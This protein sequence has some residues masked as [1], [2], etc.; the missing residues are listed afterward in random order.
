MMTTDGIIFECEC[1][2]TKTHRVTFDGGESTD[3][4][5]IEM[6]QTCYDGD[7]KMYMI[8]DEE[9]LTTNHQRKS[10][11]SQTIFSLPEQRLEDSI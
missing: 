9:I 10:N 6:C 4:Y 3:N 7:N 2:T 11:Q 1:T 5:A 8:L